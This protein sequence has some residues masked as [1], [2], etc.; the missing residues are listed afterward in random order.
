M[1]SLLADNDVEL[2]ARLIW[3]IFGHREWLD[4]GVAGLSLLR[5]ADLDPTSSDRTIWLHCQTNDMLLITGNRN[6]EGPDSLG[7]VLSELNTANHLPV[8]TIGVPQRVVEF[9]YREN[10][11]YRIADVATSLDRV[12]GSGRLFIP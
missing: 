2:Y 6:E 8:L 10:C 3:T 4:L 1:I 11:A 12:R 5:D 9:E 7:R